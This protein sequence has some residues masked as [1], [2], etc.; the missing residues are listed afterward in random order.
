M[1]EEKRENTEPL[2][3]Y[4]PEPDEVVS[5]YAPRAK[6]G[7][8]VVSYYVQNKPLPGKAQRAEMPQPAKK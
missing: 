8:E 2:N 4:L 6:E 5:W 3:D 1:F 7:Q